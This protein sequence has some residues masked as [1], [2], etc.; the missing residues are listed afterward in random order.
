NNGRFE[1]RRP[2]ELCHTGPAAF[3]HQTIYSNNPVPSTSGDNYYNHGSGPRSP[4]YRQEGNYD[5]PKSPLHIHSISEEGHYDCPKSPLLVYNHSEGN[6]DCPKSPVRVNSLSGEGNYD[7]PKSPVSLHS[8]QDHYS[9]PGSPLMVNEVETLYDSPK[10]NA[11]V[12]S[13]PTYDLPRRPSQGVFNPTNDTAGC[14]LY[15]SPRSQVTPNHVPSTH[16][17]DLQMYDTP[18]ANHTGLSKN[19]VFH[20]DILDP[21]YA[22]QNEICKRQFTYELEGIIGKLNKK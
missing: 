14:M 5:H 21:I 9:I 11:A 22:N 6:Y 13:E 10:S 8:T 19:Q 1:P 12:D 18:K 16:E 17:E 7:C 3:E 2:S 20:S 15:D 4:S